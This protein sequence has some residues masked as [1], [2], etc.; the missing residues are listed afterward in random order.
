MK[1]VIVLIS[2]AFFVSLVLFI[3]KCYAAKNYRTVDISDYIKVTYTGL[4]GKGKAQLSVDADK[5]Y[6][7]LAG[8]EK[9][10]VVLSKIK[11]V[12]H[13]IT[14]EADNTNLKN[15]KNMEVKVTYDKELAGKVGC[16]FKNLGYSIRVNGL[17]EGNKIDIFKNVEVV[18]AGVSP[19]AYA[20]VL[21]RWTED[22]LK[23]IS[24]TI[25]NPTG[26]SKG[27][28]VVVKCEASEDDMMARGYLVDSF[29]KEFKVD[30]VNSYISDLSEIDAEELKTIKDE[31]IETIKTETE[32]LRF[33]MFYKATNDSTYLFQF[34]NE[35]VNSTEFVKAEF[36]NKK[37]NAEPSTRNY[38]YLLFK[39]NIT[40]G[41]A[42]ADIYFAFEYLDGILTTEDKC[43][44]AH[45][46]QST[47]YICGMD[48]E[49]I[50]SRT[51]QSKEVSYQIT[52]ISGLE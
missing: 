31:A 4:E 52:E 5:L 35:W 25:E 28:T 12:I 17:S 32:S 20:T 27:D 14:I 1:F 49:N 42:T 21:N 23:N 15:G 6:K 37:E 11:D 9:N 18:V 36:L 41:T 38:I 7:H 33:R 47:R 50:Y 48:Y 19:E 8:D 2:V 51:I 40:N 44:I 24:F 22:D 46:K 3:T 29:T 43:A 34:N 45:D 16:K 39:S 30:K 10:T 26:I 13:T